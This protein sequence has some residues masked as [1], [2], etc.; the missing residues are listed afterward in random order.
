M[1]V[2]VPAAGHTRTV[3]V[4]IIAFHIINE[5]TPLRSDLYPA[6]ANIGFNNQILCTTAK[7]LIS[8]TEPP[9]RILLKLVVFIL[10]SAYTFKFFYTPRRKYLR[11]LAKPFPTCILELNLTDFCV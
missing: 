7:T 9:Q 3:N 11:I 10:K 6:L 2:R 4:L 1:C 5:T 8:F